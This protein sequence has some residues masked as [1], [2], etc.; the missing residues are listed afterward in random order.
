[1]AILENYSLEDLWLMSADARQCQNTQ[2]DIPSREG[3]GAGRFRHE[4]AGFSSID[5]NG[6]AVRVN[7]I[8]SPYTLFPHH[9]AI[10]PAFFRLPSV[11]ILTS[12]A[13]SPLHTS[14]PK[15]PWRRISWIDSES[16]RLPD[17]SLHRPSTY[18]RT[19]PTISCQ[20][21]AAKS[22]PS[23]ENGC[24]SSIECAIYHGLASRVL[25]R[26]FLPEDLASF[27]LRFA[28]SGFT[29]RTFQDDPGLLSI[30]VYAF[31]SL[32][33]QAL[34]DMANIHVVACLTWL[35]LRRLLCM[36]STATSFHVFM[37]S[38]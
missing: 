7:A 28:K 4:D 20:L 3:S 14:N 38:R 13:M 36:G 17:V 10:V 23:S 37:Y 31:D 34:V 22:A 16:I 2:D 25:F 18:T 32:D 21:P 33:S 11:R 27:I 6:V 9:C 29:Q 15:I 30:R 12:A 35:A 1:M 8:S 24:G 19:P 26:H 5:E